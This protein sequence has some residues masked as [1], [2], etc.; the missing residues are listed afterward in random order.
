MKNPI[1]SHKLTP[2]RVERGF[3]LIATLSLMILLTLL[4]VG[5]L[6]LSAVSLRRG[7]QAAAQAEAQANARLA[8]IIALGELQKEMGPDMRVSAESALFDTN[9]ETETIEG[10]EQS[11]WL[12]SYDSWGDW[13]NAT[14][15]PPGDSPLKIDAT[16]EPRR[17]KM[18]RRWLLSMPLNA[19]T[20]INAP[21]TLAW[22]NSNSVVL[23]GEGSLGK[24]SRPDQ[25]TRAYLTPI[26]KTGKHAWWIGPENHKARIDMA[27]K[28]RTLNMDEWQ[29]AQGNT[30][31]VGVG[32]LA[33]MEKLDDDASLCGKLITTQTLRAAQVAEEKVKHHF[34]DLT[35]N[36]QGVLAS[37]RTGHLKKDLSLLLEND[38]NN[39][40]AEYKFNA[41]TDAREPSIRPMSPELVA[42]NPKIPTR[43]FQ[44]WTQMRNFYRLY[45][46]TSDATVAGTSAAAVL[47]TTGSNRWTD[48]ASSTGLS[49]VAAN[50]WK[51][52][53]AYLRVPVVAKITFIH[54]LMSQFVSV[55]NYRLFLVYSPVYTLW[56]PY[57]VELRIPDAKFTIFSAAYRIWPFAGQMY[58]GTTPIGGLGNLDG[59][60]VNSPLRSGTGGDIVFKP[61]EFRVFSHATRYQGIT[62]VD[63]VPG[64]DPQAIGGQRMQLPAFPLAP[65]PSTA[66]RL[67]RPSDNPGYMT[68]F[69]YSIWGGNVNNG[70]TPGSLDLV[71]GWQL[72][73]TNN[74]GLASN[75]QIDWLKKDQCFTPITKADP[76]QL[77]RFS[78]ADGNP[79]PVGYHQLVI[80]GLSEFDYESINWG[81][82]W[83]CRNWIQAPPF[84]FGSALYASENDQILHTQRIDCPYAVNFGPTSMAEIPKLIFHNGLQAFL[85]SGSNPFEKVSSVAALELPTAPFG[86]LA[87]FA[88]MRINPGWTNAAMMN[89]AVTVAAYNPPD[90]PARLDTKLS[91]MSCA[92]LKSQTYQSGITGPGIGNSFLHPMIPRNDVYHFFDNS[93]SQDP[94][95]RQDPLGL[96]QANNNMFYNDY[97]DHVFLLNDVLWDDYFVSSLADQKRP[98]VSEALSLDENL[99][100]LT[101]GEKISNSRFRYDSG[102]KTAAEIKAE[103]KAADGYLKAAKSLVVDGMFNVNSTSVAAWHALFA[104]IRE[105][106]AVYRD[107]NGNLEKITVPSGKRIVLARFDTETSDQDMDDPEG[108]VTMPD[109]SSGWSGVRFLDDSQLQTLA[110]ECVKQVKQRGP[111]LNF[112]E[113]INR[114]LSND[115][116][117]TMGALQS[118]IDFDD[119]DP[120]SGSIN[121]NFKHGPDFMLKTSQ[122][123]DHAFSTPE[124]AVGSRFAGIPGYVIQSDLL[125]PIANTLSVRDDTFRIRAYGEALDTDGKV[126][127]RAWCEAVV[128][129]MPEYIDSTND[130]SVPARLLDLT[131]GTVN[132]INSKYGTFSDNDTLT[133]LNRSF[134]RKFRIESFRWLNKD[135][136]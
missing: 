83:R 121:Y 56:N 17:A 131:G 48:L 1:Q 111:F 103:L 69:S 43:H 8:L 117:G 62:A 128:Q 109:G 18:F 22:D 124:A 96:T 89:P 61:G 94:V 49:S 33:G 116:L 118:A 2:D 20:Q 82:D 30:A 26:G 91:S 5:L 46:T 11:H 19:E 99:D 127:A 126:I 40:P 73:P 81:K 106:Q 65:P 136:V 47:R 3:A 67:W 31:E 50:A 54:S 114:R 52:S 6:S 76:N 129:R 101:K 59:N 23:V 36:S 39:L 125:K 80:K 21:D 74:V 120:Q 10:V 112:A 75:Y 24:S 85:G 97:W 133:K 135:E 27:K 90:L 63:L 92:Y 105:R 53:N 87:G 108:G 77:A 113:F 32:A 4:A 79:V 130:A 38:S 15:A 107:K 66:A 100:N 55:N 60:N 93:W 9:K 14:Y 78:F 28:P 88:S 45:R 25:I 98:G 16:Y 102:G 95:N 57:N 12:A 71:N 29:T 13:L 34:F 134:G 7:T 37:V 104:G 122:L 58:A 44:S 42:K 110:E 86:S 115:A 70:N 84:Y 64:F 119:A 123:G 132:P 51:G 72:T 41:A 68:T 35:A